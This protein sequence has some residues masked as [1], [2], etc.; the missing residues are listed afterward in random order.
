MEEFLPTWGEFPIMV[1]GVS[2]LPCLG[3]LG[4]LLA[5]LPCAFLDLGGRCLRLA[6]LPAACHLPGFTAGSS[7]NIC[8]LVLLDFLY[9]ACMG[10][11]EWEG[12]DLSIQLMGRLFYTPPTILLFLLLTYH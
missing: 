2:A 4:A 7:T 10:L 5:T 1:Y 12:A 11:L 8:S 3:S 9:P 6:V